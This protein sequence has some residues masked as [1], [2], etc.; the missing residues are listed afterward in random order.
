MRLL[1]RV[2]TW[3]QSWAVGTSVLGWADHG[4]MVVHSVP[5]A[6]QASHWVLGGVG[7]QVPGAGA[8]C[9]GISTPDWRAQVMARAGA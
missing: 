8:G 5:A 6:L 9:R 1:G 4:R 3:L 7:R 2:R